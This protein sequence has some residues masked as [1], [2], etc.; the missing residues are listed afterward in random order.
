[1]WLKVTG[2]RASVVV[3][4]RGGR[5]VRWR[6]GGEAAAGTQEAPPT[7]AAPIVPQCAAPG[8][9]RAGCGLGGAWKRT[10][11]VPP[12]TWGQSTAG[13][14]RVEGGGLAGGDCRDT[15]NAELARAHGRRNLTGGAAGASAA[16]VSAC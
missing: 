2:Q 13:V 4:A 14:C 6:P 8:A 12:G 16:R 10:I 3:V 11:P 5:V 15:A 1:M 9:C 7:S